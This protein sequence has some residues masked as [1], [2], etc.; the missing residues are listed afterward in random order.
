MGAIDAFSRKPFEIAEET[1]VVPW[2]LE[3]PPVGVFAMHSMVIRGTEPVIVDTG[4]PADRE[5]WLD[6]VFGLV[7][8]EDVRWVFLS[9]DDRDHSGNLMQV[10]A[11]CPNATLLTNWFSIGRMAEEWMTP[12]PRCR[13]LNDGEELHI[14][15][16]TIAAVRPPLFDNPTT[17]G[18]FDGRTG[19]Y[20][21]ADTFALPLSAPA[22]WADDVGDDEFVQGQQFGA[23]LV[24][25]WHQWLDEQKY[26]THIDRVQQLPI[27][28]IAA[29]HGPAMSGSRIDAAFELLR[30][31]ADADPWSPFT[32]DDLDLW[33]SEAAPD[34]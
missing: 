20:W 7:D 28:T 11:A 27:K 25:P 33:L 24:S 34:E 3:A 19:V 15:D 9:H 31:I 4:S 13:F 30:N 6:S 22:E 26:A 1:Y 23:S 8:P 5:Q 14:G 18:L 21:A 10:L 29:C 17:R 16:R 32:Q 12:L 2:Y